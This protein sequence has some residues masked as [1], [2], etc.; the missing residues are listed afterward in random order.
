VRL[1]YNLTSG[2]SAFLSSLKWY[3]IIPVARL[4]GF[5]RRRRQIVSA[6]PERPAPLGPKVVLFMHFDRG[7]RVRP[8]IIT[9]LKEFA[10]NGRSVV[11]VTN[12]GRL[13]DPAMAELREICAG[14]IVR[15]NVG[16][17]FGA[18]RDG[19]EYLG[20]PRAGT[21]ELIL[22]NDSLF[23]PLR[24]IGDLLARLDYT[25]TDIW[26]LTDSWQFRYHLQSFFLAFGPAALQSPAFAK[27][28]AS[29]RP[30]PAKSYIVRAFEIGVT[31][32]MVKAGLRCEAL[33]PYE[34]V[35]RLVDA[36]VMM[37]ITELD[38][39]AIGKLDP[40]VITRK[41]HA[42]RVRS[43][44]ARRI[45]LN[46]AADLWRQLML[47]GFPFIKRELLRENPTGVEDV[48]DWMEV[49]QD[50]FGADPLPILRDLKS[51]MK[52]KAP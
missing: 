32:A 1:L 39:T 8:Q 36:E 9:Y 50:V 26:G 47:S 6:W 19:I 23:G 49:V 20:L 29:V 13:T 28:W 4:V 43:A 27:F 33:W 51:M 30:V 3:A 25:E 15:R 11:F 21:E 41:L 10:A 40:V 46:P 2:I 37:K 16:Y 17:D 31:Q 38:E 12:S 24:P 52:D 5:L 14:V 18:W 48:G 7:G 44:A 42:L 22:A 45:A 35:I 34:K